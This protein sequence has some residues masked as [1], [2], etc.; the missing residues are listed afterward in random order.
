M[1]IYMSDTYVFLTSTWKYLVYILVFRHLPKSTV[2]LHYIPPSGLERHALS[3]ACHMIS[4]C[5]RFCHKQ[6]SL[7]EQEFQ[8]ERY[9]TSMIIN[10]NMMMSLPPFNQL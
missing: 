6:K 2:E 3:M 5:R 4:A 8:R 10:G 1:L 7:Y 9:Y